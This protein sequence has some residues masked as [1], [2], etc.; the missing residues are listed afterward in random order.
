MYTFAILWSQWNKFFSIDIFDSDA[1]IT[2]NPTTSSSNNFLF[3][4]VTQFNSSQLLSLFSL[5]LSVMFNYPPRLPHLHS[6]FLLYVCPLFDKNNKKR[7]REEASMCPKLLTSSTRETKTA[8][9]EWL[10]RL[11]LPLCVKR[12]KRYTSQFV[13]AV[14]LFY[15]LSSSN[16]LTVSPFSLLL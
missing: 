15:F 14:F 10:I 2:K 9:I 4:L 3:L 1:N 12:L 16:S 7:G 8:I 13:S 5:M 6:S 11:V